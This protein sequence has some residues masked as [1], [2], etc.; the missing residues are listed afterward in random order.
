[1]GISV[2]IRRYEQTFR[3]RIAGVTKQNADG[4]DRQALI[5]TLRLGE[6]INLV[7][8]PTNP[9]D[10]YAI[11]VFQTSGKQLGYIPAGNRRLADHMDMGGCVSAKIVKIGRA[12]GILGLFFRAFRKP[13]GCVIEISEGSFSPEVLPYTAESR[14]I[15][16][17]IETDPTI[18]MTHH[19]KAISM[20][21]AADAQL[22]CIV[23]TRPVK[24]AWRR[25]RY[26]V[27]RLS[28]LLEKCGEFQK[29]QEV[30]LQYEQFSDVFGLTSADRK[31]V[32]ARKQR[33]TRKLNE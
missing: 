27:N 31:S 32:D 21:P 13:Y 23:N 7:R 1:M 18:E 3:T 10:K 33:L 30:I 22:M 8:E 9:Y 26:P 24:A 14:K 19:T 20:H 28:L 2:E 16:E 4:T 12:S 6:T 29:A 11:A 15:E 17:L 5:K 25:A